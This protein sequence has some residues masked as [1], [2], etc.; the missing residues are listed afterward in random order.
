MAS[1][2]R[3]R[4]GSRS[5]SSEAA[6]VARTSG[7]GRVIRKRAQSTFALVTGE[8]RAD[9]ASVRRST[10]PRHAWGI[11]DTDRAAAILRS[12]TIEGNPT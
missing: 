6:H 5:R 2:N 1:K 12:L 3:R 9:L 11:T 7:Q 8:G 10:S 4:K